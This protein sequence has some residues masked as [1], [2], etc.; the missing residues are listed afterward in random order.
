MSS[1]FN[2]FIVITWDFVFALLDNPDKTA[3][4]I[5][6]SLK[7]DEKKKVWEM[8]SGWY[9]QK[10]FDYPDGKGVLDGQL[11]PSGRLITARARGIITKNN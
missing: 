8:C 6:R 2:E 1:N 10:W 7:H 3:R 4:Q 11:T 5:A 9:S